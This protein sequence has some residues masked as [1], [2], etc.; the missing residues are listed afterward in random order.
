MMKMVKKKE[1]EKMTKNTEN[2]NKNKYYH[3]KVTKL[4][5]LLG[6]ILVFIFFMICLSFFYFN[7]E[8]KRVKTIVESIDEYGN[9]LLQNGEKVQI[10][11]FFICD[12]GKEYNF[13]N[14]HNL[15]IGKKVILEYRINEKGYKKVEKF[16]VEGI[17]CSRRGRGN[18]WERY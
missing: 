11:G 7:K 8:Y 16:S 6:I 13:R 15:L 2:S 10:K 4:F 18:N 17:T 14:L 3:K 12:N 1:E 9:A 5:I